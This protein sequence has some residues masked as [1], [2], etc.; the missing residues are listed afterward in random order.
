MWIFDQKLGFLM[1]C[2]AA[3]MMVAPGMSRS[4]PATVARFSSDRGALYAGEAFQL[5]LTIY[6]SGETLDK[7]INIA[8]LPAPTDLQLRSFEELPL[9]TE[10]HDG[11]AYEVR[12]FRTWARP[13]KAGSLVLAPRLDGTTIQTTRAFF[14][15]QEMRQPLSIPVEPFT[16]T[17]HPVPLLGRPAGFSGLAGSFSFTVQAKPL[18]IAEG[19]LITLTYTIAGDWLPDTFPKPSIRTGKGLKAYELKPIPEDCSPTKQVYQQTV[20]PENS[21]VTS[22]PACSF[23]Y[24]DTRTA[25][26]KTQTG[27]PF[28]IRY[29]VEH[30]LPQP[31]YAPIQ[32]EKGSGE[33]NCRIT[34]GI[35]RK[36]L[37]KAMPRSSSGWHHQKPPRSSSHSSP[38][39]PSWKKGLVTTGSGSHVPRASAGYPNDRIIEDYAEPGSAPSRHP[40]GLTDPGSMLNTVAP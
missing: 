3:S 13:S 16:L 21:S 18:D 19:D 14:M 25:G 31:I 29:H 10:V 35:N 4:A 27:G 20:V 5:T 22:V 40:P 17:I 11:R 37:S 32:P 39:H 15:V 1:T 26:Y 36:S 12:K 34:S 6:I 28:R 33:N 7:Q 8:N 2:L 38:G 9:E 23:S 30:I 24:F